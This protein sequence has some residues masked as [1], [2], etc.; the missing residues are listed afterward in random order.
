MPAPGII[1]ETPEAT[2][3]CLL[4]RL[5]LVIAALYTGLP[6]WDFVVVVLIWGLLIFFVFDL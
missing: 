3:N 5:D 1:T 2:A 4:G 6:L